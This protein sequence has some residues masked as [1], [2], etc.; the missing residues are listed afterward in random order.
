MPSPRLLARP[1]LGRFSRRLRELR[2]A[3][4][5]SQL[6]LSRRAYMTEDFVSRMER[7]KQY[8]TLESMA[9]LALALDCDVSELILPG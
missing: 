5:F 4:G 8:P 6:E 7:A 3:A 9:L 2:A 1:V